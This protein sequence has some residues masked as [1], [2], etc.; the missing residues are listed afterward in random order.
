MLNICRIFV[1][2]RQGVDF[3]VVFALGVRRNMVR[4]RI[5]QIFGRRS[6]ESMVLG[7][8][9][10]LGYACYCRCAMKT[11][12]PEQAALVGHMKLVDSALA[13]G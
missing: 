13:W 10:Y 7:D 9:A 2:R 6:Y 4:G 1:L 5:N 12:T 8:V 3:L 11:P